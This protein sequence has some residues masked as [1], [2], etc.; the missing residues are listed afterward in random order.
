[1]AGGAVH[2]GQGAGEFHSAL[3]DKDLRDVVAAHYKPHIQSG[4]QQEGLGTGLLELLDS[5]LGTK[6][7]HGHGQEEGVETT[8]GV[9]RGRERSAGHPRFE[10][11]I[12]AD[13][14]EE[15]DGKPGYRNLAFASLSLSVSGMAEAQAH[16]EQHGG[17][18]HDANHLGDSGG[19][20]DA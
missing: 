7:S 15:V 2:G 20:G 18:H 13:G 4:G 5:G 3:S 12:D 9:L 11:G 6:G 10:Q 16:H 19:I 1:M 8:D 17:E 14:Y